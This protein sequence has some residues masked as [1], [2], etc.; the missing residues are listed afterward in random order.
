MVSPS[1]MPYLVLF[2]S[3]LSNHR[4][5]CFHLMFHGALFGVAVYLGISTA[6]GPVFIINRDFAI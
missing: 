3:M 5:N 1:V 4:A 2:F 6:G